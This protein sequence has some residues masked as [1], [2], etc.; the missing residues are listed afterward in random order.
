MK[1]RLVSDDG[2]VGRSETGLFSVRSVGHRDGERRRRGRGARVR[3][4][5]GVF[6]SICLS[7]FAAEGAPRYVGSETCD[8]KSFYTGKV[9]FSIQ[10]I[11]VSP[12]HEDFPGECVHSWD[13]KDPDAY[14]GK[15]VLVVG[16]GNSGGDIAVEISRYAEMVDK[17]EKV[18]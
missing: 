8:K 14:R 16:I 6:G 17:G 18:F 12:G 4:S 13:Y 2:N 7:V 9:T 1:R 10:V 5:S 3:C 15:R 11:L